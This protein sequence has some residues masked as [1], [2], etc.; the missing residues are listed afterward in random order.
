AR[1]PG[2]ALRAA[3]ARGGCGRLGVR[4]ILAGSIAPLG[5]AYVI[6]LAAQACGTGDTVA[7]DQ[8]Q[9]PAK[10]EVLASVG[11]SAARIRERLGES[12]GSIQRFNVAVPNATTPSLEALKAYSMGVHT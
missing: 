3:G 4:A 12:I 10:T 1:A 6:T 11:G 8:V 5:P 9:A 7:R 2:G